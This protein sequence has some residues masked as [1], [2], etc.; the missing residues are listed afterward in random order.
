MPTPRPI[1]VA[2]VGAITGMSR[3]WPSSPIAPRAPTSASTAVTMGIPMAT[4]EPKA[5]VRITIA[6]RRPTTSLLS[7]CGLDSSLP[8]G[9]PAATVR[10]AFRAGGSAA[11][12]TAWAS[13]A[14]MSPEPTSISTEMNA[15]RPLFESWAAPS[16][17]KGFTALTTC[18]TLRIA[19]A[20]A[21]I[22]FWLVPPSSS[23][24]VAV[25]KTIGLLPF[26]CGGNCSA[27]RSVAR[28]LSVPGRLWSLD[29]SAPTT[30][31]TRMT[32][33]T[34]MTQASRTTNRW[35]TMNRP[36]L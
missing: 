15:I 16:W 25:E 30:K 20:A 31:T 14:V 22:A 13:S 7:V 11:S 27:S 26:C 12:S 21:L 4:A 18:G 17:L 19:V 36:S 2:R 10:P 34:A 3:T 6:T 35:A 1:I 29:V 9:P 32:P 23:F 28:W 8:T 24:P 5:R 33:A